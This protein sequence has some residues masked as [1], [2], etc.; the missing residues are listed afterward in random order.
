[1]FNPLNANSCQGGFRNSKALGGKM[2][3]HR[4]LYNTSSNDNLTTKST[5]HVKAYFSP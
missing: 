3:L 2:Q 5:G 4:K 1:M